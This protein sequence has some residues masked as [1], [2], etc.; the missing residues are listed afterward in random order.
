MT[1]F[2]DL[3][4]YTYLPDTV[5]PGVELSNIGW[6]DAAHPFPQGSTSPEF[7][8]KLTELCAHHQTA[9]ARGWHS[10]NLTH[11]EGAPPY[12]FTVVV[13]EETIRLGSAE[14]RVPASGNRWFTAPTLI[15]HYVLDHAYLPPAEF[16][17][18][19][20]SGS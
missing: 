16:V 9:Q 6:L 17:E 12:P 5:P 11:P 4:P 19:V 7:I 13:G 15:L 18:A 20:L 3:T 2:P 8:K 10:C 14:I 1:Y